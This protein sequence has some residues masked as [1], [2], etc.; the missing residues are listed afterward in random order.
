MSRDVV[1]N[2]SRS[3][4]LWW[5]RE[6]GGN[7]QLV[8]G[9]LNPLPLGPVQHGMVPVAV[10][11]NGGGV[12]LSFQTG[13]VTVDVTAGY[14]VLALPFTTLREV[15]LSGSL[16]PRDKQRGIREYGMGPESTRQSRTRASSRVPSKANA[17]LASCSLHWRD[18]HA[19]GRSVACPSTRLHR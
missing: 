13:L 3:F 5:E 8:T 1:W 11:E 7:D 17:P 4:A 12:A 10:K 18:Q 9:M 2:C 6:T 19:R 15:D 14:V 16:L